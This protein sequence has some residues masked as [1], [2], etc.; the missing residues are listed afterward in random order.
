M[1]FDWYGFA[2]LS[3]LLEGLRAH[4]ERC[5]EGHICPQCGQDVGAGIGTGRLSDGIF[6]SLSCYANFRAVEH[7]FFNPP[8]RN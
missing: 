1:G 5:L 6:C 3:S 7:R 8:S 4:K 2:D